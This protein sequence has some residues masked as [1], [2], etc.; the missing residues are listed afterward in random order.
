MPFRRT[1]FQKKEAITEV[2]ASL[3]FGYPEA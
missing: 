3:V 1:A 2:M